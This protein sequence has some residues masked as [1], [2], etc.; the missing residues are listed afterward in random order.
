MKNLYIGVNTVLNLL[1]FIVTVAGVFNSNLIKMKRYRKTT[2]AVYTLR[3]NPEVF[4]ALHRKKSLWL[5][6]NLF[7]DR[8]RM[9]RE[10]YIEIAHSHE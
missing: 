4:I 7:Y 10:F 6:Q 5:L 2:D 3:Y 8:E 9:F 1:R